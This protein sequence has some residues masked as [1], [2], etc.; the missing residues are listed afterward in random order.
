MQL[1]SWFHKSLPAYIPNFRPVCDCVYSKQP[2]VAFVA[3]PVLCELRTVLGLAGAA[4]SQLSG[5][6]PVQLSALPVCREH[7]CSFFN[8]VGHLV[9]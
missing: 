9:F 6:W 1:K 3:F 7:I 8:F 4:A 5:K 2:F